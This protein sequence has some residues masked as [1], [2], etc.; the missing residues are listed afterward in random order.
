VENALKILLL[1]DTNSEH[2]E[3]WA[4]SLAKRGISI[5]LFSF[6]KAPYQWYQNIENIEMLYEPDTVLSGTGL[7]EKVNYFK[8]ISLLKKLVKKFNPD[9][10]HAHYA[11][12]YGLI[13]ALSSFKP[14]IISVWGSDIFDFPKQNIIY[15]QLLKY[16]LSK[17]NVICSTSNCMK[18][19]A[20]LYTN[21]SID[22]IPFGI[23]VNKFNRLSNELPFKSNDEIHIGNIKSLESKYGIDILIYAFNELCKKYTRKKLVLHLVG[24]G[25]E[26]DAYMQL[27]K[28]LG[29][30]ESVIFTG[31]IAHDEISEYHKK[32]D[33]FICLSILDSESFGVSLVEAMASKTFVIASNVA[34]FKEV[35]GSDNECG[36][37]VS[38]KSVSE[39][40]DAMMEIID[41]PIQAH[42]KAENAR[43]R[44]MRLYNWEDNIKQMIDV[45]SQLMKK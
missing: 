33:I 9:I 32:L 5:G 19:E 8:H 4:I 45:Y 12:S 44:A 3:K 6:N 23:D 15:R 16:A 35:L 27:V 7:I 13:G 39:A 24:S 25:S 20:A 40:V 38:V 11:T 26:K 21:K 42:R 34:G 30:S 28:E 22:V 31:R 1:S 14:L 2:T 17:A 41:N 10:L 37:L 18:D 36:R 43:N 29:I